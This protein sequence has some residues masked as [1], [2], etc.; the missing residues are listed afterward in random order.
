MER[1]KVAVYFQHSE[2]PGEI[3]T[4]V[5]YMVDKERKK[6]KAD[7]S[8]PVDGSFNNQGNL[9]MS[10]VLGNHKI[11]RSLHLPTRSL[12]IYIEALT[13]FSHLFSPDSHI[14]TLLSQS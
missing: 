11:C 3:Q 4:S 8:K 1:T 13:G 2:F 9:Y 10:L 12:I 14:D 5:S 6:K 7:H